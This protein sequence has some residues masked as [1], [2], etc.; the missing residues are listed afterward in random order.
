MAE[1]KATSSYSR[2]DFDSIC[3]GVLFLVKNPEYVEKLHKQ[4]DADRFFPND[5]SPNV[6]AL[7]F[8]VKTILDIRQYHGGSVMISEGYVADRVKSNM[9]SDTQKAASMLWTSIMCD[10]KYTRDASDRGIQ[11]TF[12]DFL[13]VVEIIKWSEK[14]AGDYKRGHIA[15]AVRG[16]KD[17][18]ALLDTIRFDGVE[19]ISD[20]SEMDLTGLLKFLA[21][22]EKGED[23]F[24]LGCKELDTDLGGFE[25]RAL[26]VFIGAT[27]SGKS[28]MSHHLI[29]QAIAQNKTVHITI[30]EDRPQSFMRRLVAA[31]S[32]IEIRR[33]KHES[34][35]FTPD[36]IKTIEYAK[37]QLTQYVR[38]DYGY[39]ESLE[40]IHRRKLEYDAERV[41]KGLPAYDIDIVDYTGHIADKAPGEKTYEKFRNAFA[42]RKNFALINNKIVFDFAQ[43]NRGG[44][45]KQRGKEVAPLNHGD[46]AGSYD[47][48]QVC[49]NIISINRSDD[50][51]DQ[52][53]V[54][55]V[56]SKVKDGIM[57]RVGY[58]VGEN[59]K[60]ARWEMERFNGQ[61]IDIAQTVTL[62]DEKDKTF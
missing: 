59:W 26:H 7:R 32:G 24:F 33:L 8:I 40:T 34:Q 53:E 22:S 14:F 15:N 17:L 43:V 50:N 52:N 25:R 39:G 1:Q 10:P 38:I 61:V 19:A 60:C 47:L 4:L 11:Q 56:I 21:A 57:K 31:I 20:L 37:N 30:C 13:R 49:D 36:E 16:M 42:E 2:F 55:L 44:F 51:K 41:A 29:R 12:L 5:E 9:D 28:M 6:K 54:L 46:L 3:S 23:I 18:T 35:S 45:Q 62:K 48:S 27:N 58:K